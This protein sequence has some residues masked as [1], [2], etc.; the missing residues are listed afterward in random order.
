M[1]SFDWQSIDDSEYGRRATIAFAFRLMLT[2]RPE[3]LKQAS[4]LLPPIT[5]Y[6]TR[7]HA[8]LTALMI[9]A[10]HNDEVVL[11]T[12]LD[13]GANPNTEVQS[14]GPGT[15]CANAIHPETQHWT[16]LTF[17]ACRGNYA[18]VR[19]LLQRGSLHNRPQRMNVKTNH[20]LNC[21]PKVR[22]SR[23]APRW[24]AIDAH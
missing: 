23:A 10:I 2:G 6:D 24:P 5:R 4:V 13:A 16:A 18:A 20:I 12:L 14:I 7:N 11:K 15:P 1:L 21:F 19:L 8:G 9:A 22:A 17:A 3:L